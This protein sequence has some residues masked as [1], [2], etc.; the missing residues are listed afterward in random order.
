MNRYLEKILRKYTR[1]VVWGTGNF[2]TLYKELLDDR[3]IYFVDNNEKKWGTLLE[4]KGIFSPERLKEEDIDGTLVIVCNHFFDEVS[5]QLKGYGDFDVID[6]VTMKLVQEKEK[7]PAENRRPEAEDCIIICGGIHAMWQINGSRKFIDGQIAQFHDVGFHTIESIPLLYYQTGERESAFLAVSIDGIYQGL[8]TAAELAKRY[9]KVRGMVIHSLYYSHYTMKSLLDAVR[10]ETRILYYIHDYS[11]ICFHR[12]LHRDKMLCIGTDGKMLCGSCSEDEEKRKHQ[13]FHKTV[14]GRYKVLLVAPSEDTRARVKQ[15]Y[16]DAEI[17]VL[18]HL[19]FEREPLRKQVNT[20]IRVAYVG[21]AIWHKGWEQF[22]GFVD[23]F[24]QKY[25]FYC[26]GECPDDLKIQ[27]VTYVPVGLKGADKLP[28]MTEAL[29]Q[30]GIDIAYIGSVWPETYSYTY[31]EAYE[32]GCF[33]LTSNRSGNVCS[34]VITNQNG[35]AFSSE[36]GMIA[37]LENDTVQRDVTEMSKSIKNV[38]NNREFLKY[39][40]NRL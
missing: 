6:I 3:V 13:Q 40:D 2:Y 36:I 7:E 1:I 30:Y 28:G 10:V 33:I 15:V 19:E 27:H 8:C 34:Q 5:A 39:F 29:I 32:A 22:A 25:E 12:F 37:W 9:P 38:K 23:R 24:Y 31:Y 4:K 14:F 26:L 35:L 18:P 17:V 11:C 16:S 21:A 20:R